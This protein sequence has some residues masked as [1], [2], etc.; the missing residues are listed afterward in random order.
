MT[1]VLHTWGQTLSQH[2]H[3]HC[4]IPGGAFG[5]NDQWHP[6]KS[7][8]LFPVK[9]LSR[10]YR[11]NLVSA[12]RHSAK[13]DKLSRV[14]N[15]DE[16]DQKLNTLMQKDWVV[17]SKHCLNRTD[18]IIGYLAKYTHKIAIS[19]QRIIDMN[20]DQVRFSYKDYRDDKKKVM[21][22]NTFEFIRRFLLHI[23]PKGLM[24]I[25]HYGILANRCR[26][27]SL[28]KIRKI[29][30]A[31]PPEKPKDESEETH[32][33]PCP[34]CKKGLLIFKGKIEPVTAW[35]HPAPS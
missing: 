21:A 10:H 3:L 35:G 31:P 2:V 30:A 17:Y 15:P 26:K 28:E 12:L 16:I 4:L 14:T 18:S 6:A 5:D 20:N 1:A 32:S 25:R 7:D 24:R 11:G 22:L 27:Q 23:L 33:Y 8:Y 34:K 19:N 9:A 29:L 13:K